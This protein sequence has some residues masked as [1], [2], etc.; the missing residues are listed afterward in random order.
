MTNPYIDTELETVVTLYPDQM[1]NSVYI[2][3][4]K[5]L[6]DKLL[7]K[8]YKNYGYI[9][10]IYKIVSY[11]N[12]K[13]TTDNL[14]GS[15]LF[16]VTFTCRICRVVE[17]TTIVCKIDRINPIM[18]TAVNGPITTI[19]KM[20]RTNNELFFIDT[21]NNLRFRGKEGSVVVRSDDIVKIDTLTVDFNHGD[22]EI[23]TI[24]FLNSMATDEE[25]KQFYKN[26]FV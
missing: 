14:F 9:T 20:S 15:A 7:N 1:N 2:N 13:I 26:M 5:N 6:T 18:F 22:T 8:C 25:K 21:N 3:L 17:G 24:G 23:N 4:K 11:K 16:D 12:G 10:D 19:V